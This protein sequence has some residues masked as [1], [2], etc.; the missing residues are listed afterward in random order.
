MAE[1]AAEKEMSARQQQIEHVTLSSSPLAR[2]P[3]TRA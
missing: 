3:L 1:K 2:F